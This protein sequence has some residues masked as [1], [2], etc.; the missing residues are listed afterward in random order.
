MPASH[1]KSLLAKAEHRALVMVLHANPHWTLG[2]IHELLVRG[3][4]AAA[5][6][7]V[8]LGELIAGMDQ[9]SLDQLDQLDQRGPDEEPIEA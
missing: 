4:R 8:T 9:E 1:V 2:Q 7:K 6:Q 5:L 3:P